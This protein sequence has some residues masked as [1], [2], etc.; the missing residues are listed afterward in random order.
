MSRDLLEAP[1]RVL[2][3]QAERTQI[4]LAVPAVAA[5][6]VLIDEDPTALA[7]GMG[8]MAEA[9]FGAESRSLEAEGAVKAGSV[10]ALA[11]SER[12]SEWIDRFKALLIARPS[13]DG[14]AVLEALPWHRP[15][16]RPVHDRLAAWMP[17]VAEH[18]PAL[19]LPELVGEGVA[20][21]AE[22]TAAVQVF[23]D[24]TEARRAAA[25][26]HDATR[27]QVLVA[28]REVRRLWRAAS[29]AS[30]GTMP[31][32]MVTALQQHAATRPRRFRRAP[33]VVEGPVIGD[34]AV[35]PE[36]GAVSL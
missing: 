35:L 30:K 2:A 11:V 3:D 24:A 31:P 36:P 1:L 20:L 33:V 14:A 15:G 25:L 6:F 29:R 4:Q 9:G 17:V 10:H 22:L 16:F 8:A 34:M 12:C 13:A 27:R 21:Q 28:L 5:A 19:E 7:A 23:D 32:W 18:S 26:A